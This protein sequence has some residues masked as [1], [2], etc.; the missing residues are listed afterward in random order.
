MLWV[1]CLKL[2]LS[3]SDMFATYDGVSPKKEESSKVSNPD[4]KT[5]RD[6]INTDYRQIQSDIQGKYQKDKVIKPGKV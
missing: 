3:F 4:I 2:K 1:F 5:F 6:P